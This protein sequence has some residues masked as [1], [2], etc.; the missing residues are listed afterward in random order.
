[1]DYLKT[2]TMISK[3]N[4]LYMDEK[5][6]PYGLCSA[7]YIYIMRISNFPGSSQMELKEIIGVDASNVSR[8]VE[9]LKREGYIITEK[10]DNDKRMYKIYPTEKCH[11][12]KGIVLGI[13]NEWEEKV[14]KNFSSKDKEELCISLDRLINAVKDI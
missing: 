7:N 8:T 2:L 11:E 13:K 12:M 10:S 14:F 9:F 1:M 4:R 6:K 3:Y 5:L